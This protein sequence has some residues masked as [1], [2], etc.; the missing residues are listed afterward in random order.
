MVDGKDIMPEIARVAK[1]MS[2]F[3]EKV[4]S[5]EWKGFT[6]KKIRNVVNIGIGGSDLGPVMAYEALKFYSQRDL[7]F[8]FVSNVDGTHMAE[9]LR[10]CHPEETLFI[11][12]SKTFTTEETMTNATTAKDWLLETLHDTAAVRNHF[13]ALSKECILN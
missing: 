9:T 12:A 7:S 10:V 11:I 13:V 1:K 3:S 4:R 6:G 8:Y 5:G 2:E